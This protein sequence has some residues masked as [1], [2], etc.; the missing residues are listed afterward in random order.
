MASAYTPR[1]F[2]TSDYIVRYVQNEL[3]SVS[4]SIT[5]IVQTLDGKLPLRTYKVANLPTGIKAGTLCNVS[6]GAASLAWG[7]TVTGGGTASYLVRYNGTNWTV[8]GK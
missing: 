5:S 7:V 4:Q 8:V 2:T 3:G 1:P 6:D